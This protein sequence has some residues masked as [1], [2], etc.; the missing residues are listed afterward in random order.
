MLFISSGNESAIYYEVDL[1]VSSLPNQKVTV[2]AKAHIT[3]AM[4]S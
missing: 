4:A 3:M 1:F 2:I